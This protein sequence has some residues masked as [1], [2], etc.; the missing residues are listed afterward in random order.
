MTSNAQVNPRLAARP[1]GETAAGSDPAWRDLYRAGAASV[2]LYVVLGMIAPAA[3]FLT[4]DY[5]ASMNGT[6][7]LEYIA[8]HRSWW[9]A[10]QAL[11]MG[12]SVF[13]IVAF[14]AL[15][16]AL[17]R[18]SRSYTAIGATLAIAAEVLF[19]AYFPV[20]NGLV[21]LSDQ[22]AAAASAERRSALATAAEALVAQNNALGPSETVLAV[23]VLIL[24]LV[25]LKGVFHRGVAYLGVATFM[26]AIVGEALKPVLAIAYLWWWAL[27]MIWFVAVGWKLYRLGVESGRGPAGERAG[28]GEA[29]STGEAEEVQDQE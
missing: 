21:Y 12:P 26:A 8:S 7:I 6:A 20:V 19:L 27:F 25:M 29:I 23:S 22:Y 14:L 9:V 13:A 28:L 11:T 2:G 1:S 3:L 16:A 10:I 4:S 18:G 15:G 17:W 24:S 5:D